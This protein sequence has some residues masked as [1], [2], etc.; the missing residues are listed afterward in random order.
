MIDGRSVLAIIPARGG[1]KGLPNK[2][3]LP[4]AGKPLIGWTIDAALQSQSVDHCILTSDSPAIAEV[5]EQHGCE[6]PFMRPSHLASDEATTV[7][8][9]LH[10]LNEMDK[11]DLFIVL[12]PTSPLRT[13][14]DIDAAMSLMLKQN[15]QSCVSVTRADKSPQWMYHR[16]PMGQL[17]PVMPNMS[18]V[19]RR[20]DLKAVYVLNGAIYIAETEFFLKEKIFLNSESVSYLMPKERSVDIDDKMDFELAEAIIRQHNQNP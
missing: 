16:E 1:S 19:S 7:D 5:A 14:A 2:N 13:A 4:L 3:I 18:I 12:Q 20:Q 6:V 17:Q 10:A 8:T 11:H 15:A 9:I